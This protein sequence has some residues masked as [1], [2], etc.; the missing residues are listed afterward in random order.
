MTNQ[1]TNITVVLKERLE[2]DHADILI[3]NI[4]PTPGQINFKS[5]STSCHLSSGSTHL[6]HCRNDCATVAQVFV[7]HQPWQGHS[8]CFRA[9]TDHTQSAHTL[10]NPQE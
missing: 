10:G 9:K 3:Q 6:V 8:A 4:H 7:A 2:D 5:Y 1:T